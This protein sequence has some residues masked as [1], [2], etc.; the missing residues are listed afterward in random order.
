MPRRSF[1]PVLIA[2]ILLTI[3]VALAVVFSV[4][5]EELA[6]LI[7]IEPVVRVPRDYPTIQAAIDA[8]DPGEIIQVDEGLYIE[9]LFISKPVTLIAES[10]DE[11][12]P[13]N[14]TTIIDGGT[15]A[16]AIVIPPGL[17]QLPTIRGFV[18][19]NGVD[20]IQA[21]SP[22][23]A[24]YN[25]LH[26]SGNLVFYQQGGG[27]INRN[28]VYFHAANNAIRLDNIDRPLLIEN[29]RIMYSGES[30]IE[31]G[32]QNVTA[33]PA[34]IEVDIWNNMILGNSEDGIQLVDHPGD[35]QNTNRRFVISGN[36]FANNV[37]AGIGLMPQANTL[38][39]Y[40]G[41]DLV[42]PVRV[43]NNTFY[44]N[45]FGISGGD[46]LV[47]FNNIIANSLNRG[48][49][50]V[51]GAAGSNSVVAYTLF[52]NNR[53]DAEESS[54]GAGVIQGVDP[55]FEAAPNPG[56]DGTWTTL[57]D[58]YSGLVLRSGSPAID[59]G[60]AQF[61][62]NDGELIPPSPLSGFIGA[63][64]DLGW[65][66]FGAPLF[67]TPTSTPPSTST[68]LPTVTVVSPTS[69]AT[70]TTGPGSPT[71]VPASPT[72]LTATPLPATTSAPA[73]PTVTPPSPSPAATSTNTATAQVTIASIS[74]A[75]AQANTT[76]TMTITGTG[77]QT[78]AI[79]SFEGG[80]GLPQQ[81]MG[82]QV[83]DSATIIVTVNAQNDGS[84]GQQAWDVRVT[85]P[86]TSTVVL[87]DAFT[88]TPAP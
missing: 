73:S 67:M 16:P 49:S 61:Q 11:I 44:G 14:N 63:A 48:I 84:A 69:Q 85:N 3:I 57:D 81:V 8:V 72:A 27:G 15:A 80:L 54:L 13:A 1:N 53:S 70:Q 45:D 37:K 36:L 26:T 17:T 23:I 2:A 29:N 43:F 77:F 71:P 19:R 21:S 79:V 24:E 82:I 66:E 40:S 39:D 18:I 59:K 56:P 35:P 75:T 58:D 55:L 34:M 28:N 87:A 33:P 42:E 9:N 31:I 41:A 6:R 52:H 20:G 60:V 5:A 51:Q 76:V 25:F 88:V 86:D 78:G 64:P 50:R 30:G 65:R 22:F 83:I 46:N 4:G 68:P 12:N 38:E 10:F 47:A 74:P 62:A 7:G 32:L